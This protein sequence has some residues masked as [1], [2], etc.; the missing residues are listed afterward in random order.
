MDGR[1][2]PQMSALVKSLS[3]KDRDFWCTKSIEKVSAPL[4]W[5]FDYYGFATYFYITKNKRKE[6]LQYTYLKYFKFHNWICE[7][8]LAEDHH[9]DLVLNTIYVKNK[10]V[11][12]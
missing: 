7:Y 2:K 6:K 3:V 12:S 1:T 8:N 9:K 11:W 5:G 4:F 10:K